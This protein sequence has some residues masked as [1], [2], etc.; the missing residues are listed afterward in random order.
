MDLLGGHQ[1][2]AGR[3]VEAHLMAEH[4]KGPG[5]GAVA[6]LYSLVQDPVEEVVVLK[7]EAIVS[8]RSPT[9]GECASLLFPIRRSAP[10]G[11]A[12][13]RE[14]GIEAGPEHGYRH[15]MARFDV[16]AMIERYRVRADAVKDRPL[17]PVAGQERQKFIEQAEI[18]YTDFALIAHASWS[19]EN[20]ELVLRIPLGSGD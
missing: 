10:D 3:E 14:S 11:P 19:V 20:N 13:W 12:R 6:L 8:A 9:T 2:E 4:G 15:G 1:R 7:H 5:A 18:D 17:P 16:D